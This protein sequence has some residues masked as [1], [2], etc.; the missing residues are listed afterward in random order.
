MEILNSYIANNYLQL[1]KYY[2]QLQ[3]EIANR[4]ETIVVTKEFIRILDTKYGS[5]LMTEPKDISDLK[6]RYL[7]LFESKLDEQHWD[8]SVYLIAGNL[9]HVVFT[10]YTEEGLTAK[11]FGEKIGYAEKEIIELTRDGKVTNNLLDAICKH[12]GIRKTSDFTRYIS[13]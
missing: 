5:T 10:L 8:L 11:E 7:K 3:L 6:E 12:F 13:N 9:R 1:L 4:R 2:Q